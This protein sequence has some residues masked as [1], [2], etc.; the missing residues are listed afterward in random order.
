M[1][2]IATYDIIHSIA[3]KL[4]TQNPS[5]LVVIN[6]DFNHNTSE[7]TLPTFH[8]YFPQRMHTLLMPV[9]L[10]PTLSAPYLTDPYLTA[11]QVS[12]QLERLQALMAL[13]LEY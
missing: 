1:T 13:A 2:Y 6:G 7:K 9:E 5:D 8:Q 3:A 10:T 12:K 4:Q 11:G